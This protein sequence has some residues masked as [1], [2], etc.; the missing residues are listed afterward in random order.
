MHH[1]FRAA[2][3]AGPPSRLHRARLTFTAIWRTLVFL[4]K[5]MPMLPSRALNVLIP[6]PIVTKLRYPTS[7]G[8]VEGDLYRPATPGPHPGM[9]MCLGVIPID[10]DHPQIPRLGEA[11]ARSGFAALL[12]W[13]PAMRD[14]RL[15]VDDVADIAS[16]Y[17]HL[18]EQPE[19]DPAR[20]GLFGTCVGGS[21]VLM[22]AADQRIRGRVQFVGTFAPFSSMWTLAEDV[23]SASRELDGKRIPWEVDQLT[24]AVYVRTLTEDLPPDEAARLR[25]VQAEDGIGTDTT[26]LSDTGKLVASLLKPQTP[27]GAHSLLHQLPASQQQ[28][29]TDMS[30]ITYLSDIRAPL[31]IISHDRDDTVVPVGESRRMMQALEARPGARYT[32]FE[33]FQHADP[34]KRSLAPLK[35]AKELGKFASGLYPMFRKSLGS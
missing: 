4:L 33:M 8:T 32:E 10:V 14:R 24:R 28:Q 3:T 25:V 27:D 18:L 2:L 5:V 20:S 6:E 26:Y 11:L 12:Y 7:R 29:L 17:A 23:A 15:A 35:L 9:V 16:A 19:I 22:A 21:F 31:V 13:S 34:T 30:P 1:G